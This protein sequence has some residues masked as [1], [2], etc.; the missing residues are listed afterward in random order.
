MSDLL[1][2]DCFDAIWTLRNLPATMDDHTYEKVI[3]RLRLPYFRKPSPSTHIQLSTL[4]S[5]V[6][7]HEQYG[8]Y[9]LSDAFCHW[10]MIRYSLL[11]MK[12]YQGESLNT[13]V[14]SNGTTGSAMLLKAKH[15]L[16][17][18]KDLLGSKVPLAPIERQLVSDLYRVC[19]EF[20]DLYECLQVPEV[21]QQKTRTQLELFKE[22][23]MRRAW[24]PD[25]MKHNLSVDEYREIFGTEEFEQFVP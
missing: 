2:P 17:E 20:I 1:I 9:V 12:R 4:Q 15:L 5:I 10:V 21:I 18:S 22:E 3:S 11:I 23:L 6:Y 24:H 14:K 19:K 25:R 7:I 8:G 13:L 16:N